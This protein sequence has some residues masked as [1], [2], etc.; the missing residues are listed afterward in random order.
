MWGDQILG[1]CKGAGENSLGKILMYIL[2]ELIKSQNNPLGF[3]ADEVGGEHENGCG[4]RPNGTP[5]GE[6]SNMSCGAC[7]VYLEANKTLH[8]IERMLSEGI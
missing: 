7:P 1:V 4:W 3:I 5:C 6:C 2:E 8:D